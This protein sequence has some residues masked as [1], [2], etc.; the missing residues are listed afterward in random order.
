M[1]AP[2]L[3]PGVTPAS[4]ASQV[5]DSLALPVES[6]LG[7]PVWT[8][9]VPAVLFFIAFAATYLLYRRFARRLGE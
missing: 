8:A 9:V 4:F 2:L 5:A 7:G 1:A 3:G 6:P